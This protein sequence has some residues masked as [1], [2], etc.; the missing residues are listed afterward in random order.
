MNLPQRSSSRTLHLRNRESSG[1][2]IS[3][4]R[5]V[6]R[7]TPPVVVRLEVAKTSKAPAGPVSSENLLQGGKVVQIMHNGEAY[8]LR[9]TRHGKL[10][11]TK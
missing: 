11:L 10:I 6:Q 7:A 3:Y 2:S 5:P 8:Q 9:A 4:V 1:A